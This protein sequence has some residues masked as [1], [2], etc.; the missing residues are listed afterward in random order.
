M[1]ATRSRTGATRATWLISHI[2]PPPRNETEASFSALYSGVILPLPGLEPEVVDS[3]NEKKKVRERVVDGRDLGRRR[4]KESADPCRWRR[5]THPCKCRA[6]KQLHFDFHPRL[7]VCSRSRIAPGITLHRAFDR[8][9]IITMIWTHT[10]V[11]RRGDRH[12]DPGD[13]RDPERASII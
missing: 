3:T 10:Y 2:P 1:R 12:R 9:L 4:Q 6:K 13:T 5:C 11:L 8:V 7:H